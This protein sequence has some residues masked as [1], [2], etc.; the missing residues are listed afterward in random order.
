MNS[1]MTATSKCESEVDT[2]DVNEEYIDDFDQDVID[3]DDYENP[4]DTIMLELSELVRIFTDSIKYKVANG[5]D[6]IDEQITRLQRIC[7]LTKRMNS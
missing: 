6:G 1:K 4:L 2:C 5:D 7:L 3:D